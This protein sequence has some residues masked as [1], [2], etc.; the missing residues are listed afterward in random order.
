MSMYEVP[1]VVPTNNV[2]YG[3]IF[4][5]IMC[6]SGLKC[7][8]CNKDSVWPQNSIPDWGTKVNYSFV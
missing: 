8:L 7:E 5:I 3:D 6:M 2:T 1:L 4:H